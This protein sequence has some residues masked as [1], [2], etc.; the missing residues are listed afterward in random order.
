MTPDAILPHLEALRRTAARC[1]AHPLVR[2][3]FGAAED[4]F[5]EACAIALAEGLRR[6]RPGA[7]VSLGEH[8]C[9]TAAGRI[10]DTI[11]WRRRRI[12]GVRFVPP[13]DLDDRVVRPRLTPDVWD[14]ARPLR[15]PHR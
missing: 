10:Y 6:Y 13:E 2:G 4:V 3:H 5:Q 11:R 12:T 1:A 9:R 15:L 8:L 7:G 14:R